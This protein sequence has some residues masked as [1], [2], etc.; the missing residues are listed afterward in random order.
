ME[1]A[2]NASDLLQSTF[3]KALAVAID[4]LAVNGN[5]S[6]K[7]EGLL[8]RIRHHR[9]RLRRHAG[10]EP[11]A[12]R[13][14]GDSQQQH[15]AECLFRFPDP[16][17]HVGQSHDRRRN[18]RGENW[19]GPPANVADLQQFSTTTMPDGTIIVGDFT[20]LLFGVRTEARI[21]MSTD[22]GTA[23]AAHQVWIKVWTRWCVNVARPA[24]FH[25]LTGITG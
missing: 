18:E 19:L 12:N 5:T 8:E 6:A 3:S 7:P 23:F 22:A 13:G 4:S 16:A 25:T 20:E 10:M 9:D 1:D 2:P 15:R 17:E 11:F 21:E 24:A 14:N